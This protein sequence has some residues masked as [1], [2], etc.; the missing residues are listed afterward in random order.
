MLERALQDLFEDQTADLPSARASVATAII[1]GRAYRARR[2]RRRIVALGAPSL[3]AVAVLA[4]AVA[5]ALSHPAVPARPAEP[6]KPGPSKALAPTQ[7]N[8]ARQ[9]ASFGWLPAGARQTATNE[10][11]TA[12]FLTAVGPRQAIWQLAVFAGG[13]CALTH[14]RLA[15]RDL[16]TAQQPTATRNAPGVDGL[17]AYWDY[18]SVL[19]F[20]YARG[21]WATLSLHG[22]NDQPDAAARAVALH[23]AAAL[24][25]TAAATATRFPAQLV[26]LPAGWAIRS[27]LSSPSGYGPLESEFQIARGSLISAPWFDSRDIPSFTIGSLSQSVA[28]CY[29]S[30]G[31]SQRVTVAGHQVIVTRIPASGSEPAEQDLCASDVDGLAVDIVTSGSHPPMDVTALFAHLRLLGPDPANWTTRPIG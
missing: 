22:P 14:R 19:I 7:F 25:F 10:S 9:Y 18:P 16:T 4:V 28:S 30:P 1:E 31:Q 2:R 5:A 12:E 8:P 29:V 6:G 20:E 21:G 26:G 11:H 15:C 24:R 27:V 3:A 17:P 13:D 23:I